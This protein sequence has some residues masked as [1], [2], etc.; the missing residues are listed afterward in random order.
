[1]RSEILGQLWP[2]LAVHL[3][4]LL[5]DATVPGGAFPLDDWPKPLTVGDAATDPPLPTLRI[6]E[7]FVRRYARP[8]RGSPGRHDRSLHRWSI[9]QHQDASEL[10]VSVELSPPDDY[11]GGLYIGKRLGYSATNGWQTAPTLPPLPQGSAVVHRGNL[12]HGVTL[13]SGE[14]WSLI[15]FFFRNCATQTAYFESMKPARKQQRRHDLG[16][17]IAATNALRDFATVVLQF[18]TGLIYSLRSSSAALLIAVGCVRL[19]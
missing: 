13:K 17:A 2:Q 10:S 5:Y 14:R 1:M 8:P 16:F 19:V 7:M 3:L 15:V 12:T 11:D 18:T 4:P 9:S 6:S